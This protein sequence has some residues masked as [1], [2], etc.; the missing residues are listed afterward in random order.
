MPSSSV[1]FPEGLLDALDRLAQTRGVSRNRLV[2]DA[3]RAL[4]EHQA[5]RWPPGFFDPPDPEALAVLRGGEDLLAGI[6]AARRS[7]SEAPF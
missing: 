6:Q 5:R 7:R 4:L 3:C 2:I 1:H